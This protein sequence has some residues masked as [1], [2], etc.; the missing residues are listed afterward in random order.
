MINSVRR[1]STEMSRDLVREIPGRQQINYICFL[2]RFK[3]RNVE[4]NV[5]VRFGGKERVR[6]IFKELRIPRFN[7]L[8]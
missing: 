2:A 8:N 3:R 1:F 6:I 4:K 5:Q 7:R